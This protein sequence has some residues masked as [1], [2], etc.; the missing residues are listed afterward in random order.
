MNKGIYCYSFRI[1]SKEF[2]FYDFWLFLRSLR[3]IGS[4]GSPPSFVQIRLSDTESSPKNSGGINRDSR[5][6]VFGVWTLEFSILDGPE[7]RIA[8]QKLY[9]D[10]QLEMSGIRNVGQQVR[11]FQTLE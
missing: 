7:H 4:S 1:V 8:C 5:F 6:P 2:V 11:K 9:I 10:S 3:C